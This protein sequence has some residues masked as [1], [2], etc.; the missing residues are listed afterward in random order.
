MKTFLLILLILILSACG[1][2]STPTTPAPTT[3]T[4]PETP[5]SIAGTWEGNI[6]YTTS[7]IAFRRF[8]IQENSG[9]YEGSV[10]VCE[11]SFG[12]DC[13]TDA[14]V[15]S[16]SIENTSIDIS[17]VEASDDFNGVVTLTATLNGDS[18]TG[19]VTIVS[20]TVGVD[21]GTVTF[22]RK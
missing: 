6:R 10:Y 2:S 20:D 9:V 16:I 13:S 7:G 21:T 1:Q 8:V 17:Y 15:M 18:F 14:I 5:S 12:S 3:P 11:S 22:S 19:D 4:N